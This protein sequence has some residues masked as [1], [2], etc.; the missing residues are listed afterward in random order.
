MAT[1]RPHHYAF[2]HVALRK[3]F[4]HDPAKVVQAL[5]ADGEKLIGEIWDEVGRM[6]QAEDGDAALL[7]ADG[8]ELSM[9]AVGPHTKAAVIMLPPPREM[10]EAY[11]VAL[12]VERPRPG[13]RF[14]IGR[15]MD[16]GRYFTLEMG[17]DILSRE[18][19]TVL[20]EWTREA[21]ANFGTGPEP[22][23]EAF[24]KRVSEILNG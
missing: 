17:M 10:P 24:V 19:R 9:H 21:H 2:G 5:E 4:F 3:A 18:R 15:M 22:M 6:I 1:P 11:F 12:V 20:C 8:L 7:P 23:V 13:P 14:H 16:P